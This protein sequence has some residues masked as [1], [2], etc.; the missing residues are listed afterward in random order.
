MIIEIIGWTFGM[1]GLMLLVGVP[2]LI[3]LG[4]IGIWLIFLL[5]VFI[6]NIQKTNPVKL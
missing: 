3:A 2:Y 4:C 1:L 5:F 6:K